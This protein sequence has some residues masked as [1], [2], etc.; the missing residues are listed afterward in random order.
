MQTGKYSRDDWKPFYTLE[1]YVR[2]ILLID[3]D[4]IEI[5]GYDCATMNE[6]DGYVDGVCLLLQAGAPKDE[7]VK[8]LYTIEKEHMGRRRNRERAGEVADKLLMVRRTIIHM[9]QYRK[10]QGR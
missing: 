8:H 1:G 9:E 3:W 2:L 6:Y 10:K 4:P 7:L 5:L